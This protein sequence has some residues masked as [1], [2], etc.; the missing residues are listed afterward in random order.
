MSVLLSSFLARPF[1]LKYVPHDQI[2]K[3]VY[4][5]YKGL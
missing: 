3:Y 2:F 5:V 4:T 1:G